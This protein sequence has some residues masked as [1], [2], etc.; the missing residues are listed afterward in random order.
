MLFGNQRPWLKV[1]VDNFLIIL[2]LFGI[3]TTFIAGKILEFSADPVI[4]ELARNKNLNIDSFQKINQFEWD[5][6]Y[7]YGPYTS[8]NNILKTHTGNLD[9]LDDA[10]EGDSISE[11]KC[12]LVFLHNNK[13]VKELV[14]RRNRID[15]SSFAK[16][17]PINKE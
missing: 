8:K 6:L 1:L 14:V 4:Q 3:A 2:T 5:H 7:I 15:L 13:I 11:G 17:S 12:Y 16:Y 10:L 9:L